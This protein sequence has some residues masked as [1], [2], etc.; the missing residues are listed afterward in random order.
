[1]EPSNR[2]QFSPGECDCET[3]A[4]W[5][6]GWNV[7]GH[8]HHTLHKSASVLVQVRGISAE[9]ECIARTT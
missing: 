8:H 4:Q 1:M 7:S 9:R 2:F 3:S 5:R 6:Y